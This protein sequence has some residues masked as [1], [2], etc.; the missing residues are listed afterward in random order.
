MSNGSV[1]LHAT[2]DTTGRFSL[3]N[4]P[5][6]DYLV[7]ATLAPYQMSPNPSNRRTGSPPGHLIVPESGC[8]YTEVELQTTSLIRGIV[9]DHS[10]RPAGGIPVAV[11]LKS[12][13]IYALR[14][15]TDTQG[16]FSISGVP[17]AD[18]YLSTGEELPTFRVPYRSVVYP[19]ARL[20]PGETS[21]PLVLRLEAPLQR[22]VATVRIVVRR[23]RP[24]GIQSRKTPFTCG[25]TTDPIVLVLDQRFPQ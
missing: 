14:A 22:I 1:T 12:Q 2:S 6:G 11:H 24:V 10:G 16:R 7:Q 3:P 19:A 18:V 4:A 20:K 5:A 21:E 8:G 23:G 9:L 15:L 17:D 13:P 25:Q